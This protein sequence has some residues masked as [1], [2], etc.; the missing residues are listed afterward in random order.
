MMTIG[1]FYCN[2]GEQEM[3]D[4]RNFCLATGHQRPLVTNSYIDIGWIN[5][6]TSGTGTAYPSRAHK[7][8]LGF[9]GIRVAKSLIFCVVVCRSLFVLFLLA[10]ILSGL[11]LLAIILSGLFLLAIILSGLFLL[12]IIL[13]GLRFTA[14]DY[15]FDIFKLF[16]K[17]SSKNK[18]V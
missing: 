18:M 13:S 9:N 1:F 16:F 6:A 8:T 14:S 12:A 7:F 11:F 2:K 17:L 5:N 3:V 4:V 10:I 15:P